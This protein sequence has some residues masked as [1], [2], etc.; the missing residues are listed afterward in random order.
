ML[1]NSVIKTSGQL[2]KLSI[3]IVGLTVGSF[4]PLFPG[5][6]ISMIAGT[7]LA[8]AAYVFGIVT[9]RCG[10]CRSLWLWEA[11][12]DASWYGSLFR[13]TEC[14]ACHKEFP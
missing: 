7:V 9:I 11:T 1:N 6:G 4:A 13:K 5:L 8:V 2:W 12:K 10:D 14:P 3:A